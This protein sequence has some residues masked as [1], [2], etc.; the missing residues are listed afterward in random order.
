MQKLVT[1]VLNVLFFDQSFHHAGRM[2][3]RPFRK[4]KN[5]H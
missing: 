3:G 5:N 4:N 1:G 2:N